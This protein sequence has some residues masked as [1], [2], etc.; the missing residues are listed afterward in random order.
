MI[1]VFHIGDLHFDA[2][3]SYLHKTA[4]HV[5]KM[6]IRLSFLS[7]IENAYNKGARVFLIPGDIFDSRPY[8]VESLEFLREAFG[9]FDE[10]NFFLSFGNHDFICDD[11]VYGLKDFFGDNV[12]IFGAETD[13]Y[14]FDSYRVYGAS[15]SEAFRT[16]S[17][18]D[19]FC[20]ENDGKINLM[21]LHGELAGTGKYNPVTLS[22]IEKSNLDYLALGHIHTFSGMNRCG[23][24]YYCYSG[25]HEGKGFDELGDKGGIFAQIDE[26][27][28][29]Y[30]FIPG[31]LRQYVELHIDAG[32]VESSVILGQKI[33]AEMKNPMNLYKIVIDGE[34][35]ENLVIDCDMLSKSLAG[36]GF[37]VK[38]TD[39]TE[40]KIDINKYLE[41]NNLLGGFAR[42]VQERMLRDPSNEEHWKNV[43]KKGYRLLR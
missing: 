1:K 25:T 29:D 42:E 10:G 14:E 12:Y 17:L 41:G 18:L 36:Y 38:V 19:G 37:Y 11:E 26:G 5:R 15:F 27:Y 24:T 33:A 28:F 30:E 43:L 22:M 3:F 39:N 31:C 32:C 6:E 35:S 34:I 7:Q 21:V 20:A 40:L 8:S 16:E 2:D 13:V 9:K 23:R 4:A